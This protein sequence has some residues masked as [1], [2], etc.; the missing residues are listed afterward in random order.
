MGGLGNYMFQISAATSLAEKN[1]DK[2]V[3]NFDGA[4]RIHR[5]INLYKDNIL[6]KVKIGNFNVNHTYKEPEFTYKLRLGTL[7]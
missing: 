5:N 4:K 6:R 7:M 1:N 3:F 2:A